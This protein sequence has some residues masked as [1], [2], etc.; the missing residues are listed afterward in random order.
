[1]E[2]SLTFHGIPLTNYTGSGTYQNGHVRIL[3]WRRFPADTLEQALLSLG[4]YPLLLDDGVR[5]GAEIENTEDLYALPHPRQPRSTLTRQ[6]RRRL[7]RL[8]KKALKLGV[9][10]EELL[11]AS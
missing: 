11:K 10:L 8:K 5:D 1:M 6:E 7:R 4:S 9:P 3:R 2:T